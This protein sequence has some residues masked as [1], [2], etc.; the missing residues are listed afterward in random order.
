MCP[1][2][3]RPCQNYDCRHNMFAYGLKL[4]RERIKETRKT[5]SIRN[6]DKLID[7]EWTLEEIGQAWGLSRERIRQIERMRWGLYWQAPCRSR[8]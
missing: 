2:L 8:V 7:S 5:R 6:C 3:S 1:D 4:D